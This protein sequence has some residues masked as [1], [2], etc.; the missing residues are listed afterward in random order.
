MKELLFQVGSAL[1]CLPI[2]FMG[3]FMAINN[4]THCTSHAMRFAWVA[5]TTAAASVVLGPLF[6]RV[7]SDFVEMIMYIGVA[8]FLAVDRRRYADRIKRLRRH[9]KFIALK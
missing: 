5:I 2:C 4:M 8:V 1:A 3:L 7:P 9:R 6:G